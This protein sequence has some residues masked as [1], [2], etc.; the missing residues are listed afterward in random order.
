MAEVSLAALEGLGVRPVASADP[1]NLVAGYVR[2]VTVNGPFKTEYN[3]YQQGSGDTFAE[4]DA[5]VSGLAHPFAVEIAYTN[6]DAAASDT[7]PSAVLEAVESDASFKN[8]T[9]HDV[10]AVTAAG[11]LVKVYGF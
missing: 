5:F 6:C 10:S 3:F 8:V 9:L 11:I 2:Y 7:A 1:A 4:D